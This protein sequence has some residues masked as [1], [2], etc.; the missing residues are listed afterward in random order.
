MCQPLLGIVPTFPPLFVGGDH[1]IHSYISLRMGLL[2][3]LC[4]VGQEG[5]HCSLLGRR[6]TFQELGLQ[7][8]S[9]NGCN[10]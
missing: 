2:D 9:Q 3:Q 5:G 4:V 8:C 7:G 1:I 10:Y 6:N